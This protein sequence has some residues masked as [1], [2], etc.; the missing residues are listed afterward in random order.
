MGLGDHAE[1]DD[2]IGMMGHSLAETTAESYGR[3]FERFAGWCER[4]PDRP[5][6]LPAERST[7]VRWLAGDV[8]RQPEDRVAAS[9]LKPYRAAINAVHKDFEYDE[10][11][12][13]HAL[14]AYVRGL[15][16]LQARRGR[17]R[18]R[19]TYLPCAVVERVLH[20]ALDPALRPATA[21]RKVKSAFR[22]AVAVCFTFAFF[23]RGAT[24]SQLLAKDVRRSPAFGTVVTLRHEK[25]HAQDSETRTLT[26]PPGA[27]VPLER[28]LDKWEAFRG[29]V[30]ST[31][32]YYRLPS[33]RRRSGFPADAIDAWVKEI[34]DHLDISAPDGESWSG[35]SLRKGAATGAHSIEVSIPK[36]CWMGGWSIQSGVV[37]D[38]IDPSCPSSAAAAVFYGWLRAGGAVGGAAG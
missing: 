13:G 36:I 37:H 24:G 4:Q 32:S 23:A 25:G 1:T 10:P 16:N 14:R 28:L 6:S 2:I 20:W 8:C 5:C 11:A 3:H 9:S 7:V 22:A 31:A 19:R 21:S 33:E 18:L 34:L 27:I 26:I 29:A 17:R 12:V 30:P 15:G 38:Y 35:H